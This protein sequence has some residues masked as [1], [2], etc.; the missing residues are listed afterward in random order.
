MGQLVTKKL[1]D[2]RHSKNQSFSVIA[3]YLV[4]IDD[5]LLIDKLRMKD[6]QENCHVSN[7]TII[8][9]CKEMGLSGFS[10][11]KFRLSE[12]L[13]LTT[14]TL[15]DSKLLDDLSSQHLNNII[16]SFDNTKKLLTDTQLSKTIRLIE[17]SK[18]INV[19][20]IG[21]TFL[22]AKDLEFKLNRIKKFAKSYNDKN[23]QYFAAK[24]SDRDT[25]SIGITYSGESESVLESLKISASQQSKTILIT[26]EKNTH[27]EDCF[28]LVIYVASTDTRNRMITTTSR[29]TLLY[30]IDLIF[31]SY[32]NLNEKE[33]TEILKHSSFM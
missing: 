30:L 25:L 17:E 1:D 6:I 19:Y 10:E 22:T 5:P 9:M 3:N 23:L 2:L 7:S 13:R 28:D 16:Q 24:N 15:N 31:F 11:M 18:I 33:I 21:S 4:S 26:N 8:R 20:A 27:L 29:L 32:N 12:N 14:N